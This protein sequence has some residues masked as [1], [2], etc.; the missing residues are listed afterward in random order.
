[1]EELAWGK[2]TDGSPNAN[3]LIHLPFKICRFL[4]ECIKTAE[5]GGDDS[6]RLLITKDPMVIICSTDAVAG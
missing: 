4:I 6:P 1:M 5:M 3:H 2:L